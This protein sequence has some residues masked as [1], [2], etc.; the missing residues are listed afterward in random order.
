MKTPIIYKVEFPITPAEHLYTKLPD[1]DA[2]KISN[3]IFEA[4]SYVESI[5]LIQEPTLIKG[6]V[7]WKPNSITS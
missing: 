5:I 1:S 6:E 7:A 3:D 2:D 4:L